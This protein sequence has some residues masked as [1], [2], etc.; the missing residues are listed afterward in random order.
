MNTK[1]IFCAL[2][3]QK[4]TS[5]YFDGVFAK[6]TLID[7]ESPPKLLVCNT[8]NVSEPGEH[9]VLFHIKKNHALFYDPLGKDFSHYG[10]EFSN[11]VDTWSTSHE[12]CSIRT[13]PLDSSLC[14]VY[15]LYFA[16][17]RCLGKSM[18][19]IVKSMKSSEFVSNFVK[20]TFYICHASKCKYLQCCSRK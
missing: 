6:D 1:Q 17:F 20:R 14:G 11:F 12:I 7:I 8:D 13:Q 15:C 10:S 5:K 2:A 18:R 9:W 16:Y 19:S 3:C 4:V